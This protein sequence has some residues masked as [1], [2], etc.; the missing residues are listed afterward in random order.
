MIEL[1]GDHF[2]SK[3][4]KMICPYRNKSWSDEKYQEECAKYE[5]KH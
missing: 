5:N 1:K 3:D 2:F 4:G